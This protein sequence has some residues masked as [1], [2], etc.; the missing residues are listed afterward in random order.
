MDECTAH[1]P[2]DHY[3]CPC[4]GRCFGWDGSPGQPKAHELSASG[5]PSCEHEESSI[6][7]ALGAGLE[8]ASLAGGTRPVNAVLKVLPKDD[9]LL[10]APVSA[11][12]M[13]E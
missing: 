10:G 3:C 12:R 11:E 1:S 5:V 7:T 9:T 6:E 2:H 13:Q 4:S 8:Q